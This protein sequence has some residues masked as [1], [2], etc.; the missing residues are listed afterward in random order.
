MMPVRRFVFSRS[1]WRRNKDK[2]TYPLQHLRIQHISIYFF[3]P[4]ITLWGFAHL[5]PLG[6]VVVCRRP[7]I[8]LPLLVQS[9]KLRVP[10]ESVDAPR[11]VR[12]GGRELAVWDEAGLHPQRLWATCR[13]WIHCKLKADGRTEGGDAKATRRER[14][15][16]KWR[17]PKRKQINLTNLKGIQRKVTDWN[18][19]TPTIDQEDHK[20][21]TE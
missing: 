13:V 20:R 1:T 6:A 12:A 11:A 17:H 14:E 4:L 19:R 21:R 18:H 5:D 16:R 8:R 9:G 15:E 3:L 10:G 2:N 7:G